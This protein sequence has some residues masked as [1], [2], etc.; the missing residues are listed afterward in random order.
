MKEKGIILNADNNLDILI[1]KDATGRIIQGLQIDDV[2]K[3][4]TYLI[5]EQHPGEV[6]AYPT[7][8][9][10][11]SDMILSHDV[12]AYKHRIQ[13]QLDAEGMNVTT[14]KVSDNGSINI[15]TDYKK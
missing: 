15:I 5:I 10:G 13:K 6:K 2:T 1:R 4:N 12:L 11:I 8:G 3:Q 9:V 14:L 7:V